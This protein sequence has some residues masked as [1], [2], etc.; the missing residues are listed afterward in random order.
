[1]GHRLT[2]VRLACDGCGALRQAKLGI[3]E[4]TLRMQLFKVGWSS[5][6]VFDVCSTCAAQGRTIETVRADAARRG[7]V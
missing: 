4:R 1:M 5:D 6:G 2:T 7:R 3:S